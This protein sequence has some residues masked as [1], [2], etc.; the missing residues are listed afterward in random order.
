MV[1]VL[2]FVTWSLVSVFGIGAAT[3]SMLSALRREYPARKRAPK[4]TTPGTPG[5]VTP[6][7]GGEA[8]PA[9][10]SASVFANEP[11]SA[12]ADILD[13]PSGE[14]LRASVQT[15]RSTGLLGYPRASFLDRA[16][17]FGLDCVLVAM[18]GALFDIMDDGGYFLLLAGYFI[19]FWTWQGTTLGGIVVGLRVVR[20]D[21][22]QPRLVDSLIRAL[23][24]LFS[25]G[26]LAI[27]VL[28]M[29]Q[30]P[31]R[32]T[33]HDKIAGTYVVRVPRELALARDGSSAG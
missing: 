23:A 11:P 29:I 1:P 21:G 30:D 18:V 7:A 3:M 14:P 26:V 25:F 6:P 31:E 27:G 16:A 24:S 33:W 22:S 13:G 8:S 19:G 4:G 28:W 5:S 17:A 12:D 32:Q 9:S 2:G 10:A 20:T 15:S